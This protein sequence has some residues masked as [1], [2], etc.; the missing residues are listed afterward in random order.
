MAC[1]RSGRS[2]TRA[3]ETG[4]VGR[5]GDEAS[6]MSRL[7]ALRSE[8]EQQRHFRREQLTLIAAEGGTR[9]PSEDADR[10]DLP[11]CG[12]EARTA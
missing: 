7:P 3:M 11:R 9:M 12:S 4:R 8:L 1:P 2:S 5:R 10:T 6:L